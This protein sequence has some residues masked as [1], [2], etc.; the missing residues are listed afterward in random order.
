MFYAAWK[1]VV[2]GSFPKVYDFDVFQNHST[3]WL[4]I[5]IPLV[6]MWLLVVGWVISDCVGSMV[7]HPISE[8]S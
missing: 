5:R 6:F 7:S 2:I 3:V 4:V 1:T 8:S